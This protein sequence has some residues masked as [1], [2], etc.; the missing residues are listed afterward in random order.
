MAVKIILRTQQTINLFR[1]III[2]TACSRYGDEIV[3]C[4]G[5][6]QE[7]RGRRTS[8]FA[9]QEQNFVRR[10]AATGKSMI[11]IGVHSYPWITDYRKFVNAFWSRSVNIRAYLKRGGHWHAK[12]YLLTKNN[13]PIFA[14]IGSSNYTRNAFSDST[15]FNIESDVII[16]NH[17]GL[18]RIITQVIEKT[19]EKSNHKINQNIINVQYSSE[20]NEGIRIKDRLSYLNKEVEKIISKCTEI[21]Q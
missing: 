5:F 17:R 1:D 9:S 6:F 11:T 10:F 7:R 8:Y 2:N 21:K 14:V 20:Q 13:Q 16:S 12:I 19:S 18:N 4:S 3:L 15:P